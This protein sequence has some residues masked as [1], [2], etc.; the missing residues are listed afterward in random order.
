MKA[1]ETRRKAR[2]F[3]KTL[4]QVSIVYRSYHFSYPCCLNQLQG[5]LYLQWY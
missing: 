1:S 2:E 5:N 3:L 4:W